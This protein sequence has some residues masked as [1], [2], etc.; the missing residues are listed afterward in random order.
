MNVFLFKAEVVFLKRALLLGCILVGVMLNGCVNPTGS[1]YSNELNGGELQLSE[2]NVQQLKFV[3]TRQ[4]PVVFIHGLLGS[5]LHTHT[6]MRLWG[7]FSYLE[8]LEG[9]CFYDLALPA[10]VNNNHDIL[11]PGGLL[12]KSRI[13]VGPFSWERENYQAV[14]SLLEAMGYRSEESAR[15]SGTLPSLFIFYYDWRKGID[16]NAADLTDFIAEKKA[17]LSKKSNR[18]IKFDL[19]GHSMGGLLA[20]YYA[21]YGAAQLG[22]GKAPLPV[23]TWKN[24]AHLDKIILIAS[25]Q[26]GYADCFYEIINGL[27]LETLAPR[28]PGAVMATFASCYQMLPDPE[29]QAVKMLDSGETVDIFD[30][31]VWQRFR[32]GL[33]DGSNESAQVLA[34]I[35][36]DMDAAERKQAAL[37][38]LARY[39]DNSRRFK[40]LIKKSAAEVP[41][42]L[43]FYCIAGVGFSTASVLSV[44]P[45]SGAV[46]IEEYAPG[47]G[48]ITLRSAAMQR[49][50]AKN[51]LNGKRTLWTQLLILDGAHMGIMRSTLFACNLYAVLQQQE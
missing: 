33:L 18:Q 32:W 16:K 30:P 45:A 36:P 2:D 27:K 46:A 35:M 47:D 24:K 49:A 26:L 17:L 12:K 1:Y 8:M 20:R 15:A 31:E 21:A 48:K 39:L 34:L 5:E 29:L 51:Y 43:N 41:S 38:L 22:Q 6:G 9:K 11:H 44:D 42:E 28:F 37:E 19:I 7:D 50:E 4:N 23:A 14:I 10:A 3:N 13:S 40:L 25:P